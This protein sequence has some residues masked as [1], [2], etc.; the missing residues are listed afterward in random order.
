MRDVYLNNLSCYLFFGY[1]IFTYLING[2][3]LY[4]TKCNMK[5]EVVD[6]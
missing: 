6:V 1:L 3:Q 2:S 4:V 5:Q